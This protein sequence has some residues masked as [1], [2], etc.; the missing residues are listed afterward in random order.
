MRLRNIKIT[1]GASTENGYSGIFLSTQNARITPSIIHINTGGKKILGNICFL[2]FVIPY[3]I[4]LYPKKGNDSTM[5]GF[6][7]SAESKFPCSNWCEERK[8]PQPGQ[9]KPVSL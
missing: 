5:S 2:K 3:E 1:Y 6:R 7:S 8:E 4:R 9:Y